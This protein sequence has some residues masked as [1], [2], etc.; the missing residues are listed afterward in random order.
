MVRIAS[1][2]L[3]RAAAGLR[4]NLTQILRAGVAAVLLALVMPAAIRAEEVAV[5]HT[6]TFAVTP[7]LPAT[8]E[9]TPGADEITAVRALLVI[10][11][12]LQRISLKR[13]GASFRGTFPSPW[14]R[15]EY[16]IQL[17]TANVGVQLSP[18]YVADQ[19]CRNS[20]LLA[21]RSRTAKLSGPR[22]ALLKEAILLDDDIRRLN[23]VEGVVSG[24]EREATGGAQ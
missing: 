18:T 8:I 10:D 11:G 19:R 4:D 21:E 9:V 7:D 12:K 14:K 22:E 23:Y 2:S 5:E 16:R 3:E 1:V 15:M 24:M 13:E 20:S 17:A 6:V